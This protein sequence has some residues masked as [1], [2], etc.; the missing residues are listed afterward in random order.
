LISIRDSADTY[1]KISAP[2]RTDWSEKH[3]VPIFTSLHALRT[4]G[5]TQVRPIALALLESKVLG[6]T[7]RKNA[8]TALEHF[9]FLY[10]AVCSRSSSGL[11]RKYGALARQIRGASKQSEAKKYVKDLADELR[12]KQPKTKEVVDAFARLEYSKHDESKKRLI[13]YFFEKYETH[14]RDGKE[15]VPDDMTLEHITPQA[16]GSGVYAMIGNLIP[17]SAALNGEAD[18]KPLVEKRVVYAKSNFRAVKAFLME[19]ADASLWTAERIRT[20][21]GDLGKLAS[22][23]IFRI[24]ENYH[25][26]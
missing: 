21:T 22:E 19:S 2:L 14:L 9:H 12:A 6:D 4:F 16:S 26:V 11:D 1:R 25:K 20:R 15:L 23:K 24:T 8:L 7:A 13:Q 18:T 3:K 10:T 17:L 5:I